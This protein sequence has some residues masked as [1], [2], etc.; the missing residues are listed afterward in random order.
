MKR[1]AVGG[2]AWLGLWAPPA[3]ADTAALP[4]ATARAAAPP[5]P[6]ASSE[7]TLSLL[8]A[9]GAGGRFEDSDVNRFG[10]GVGARV[11]VTLERPG[12]YL[13]GS[14][15][16][17]FGGEDAAGEFHTTTLSAE[18]GYD[19]SLAQGSLVVRP[20]LAL[21]LAQLATIQSDNAG[22]PLAFHG[23]PGLLFGL[24]LAPVWLSVEARNDVVAGSWSNAATV[25]I[26]AGALL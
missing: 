26:A 18:A 23:A 1:L 10:F 19:F 24:R 11:G 8:G 2:V 12:I 14:I 15:V 3:A 4:A 20:M 16:R 7:L 5:A 13:G 9:Y 21:G 22:Y 6:A 17:F 25:M